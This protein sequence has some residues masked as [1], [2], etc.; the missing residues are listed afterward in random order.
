MLRARGRLTAWLAGA[1]SG[2]A[3]SLSAV[4]T[5]AASDRLAACARP[6]MSCPA[7]ARLMQ[8]REGYGRFARGGLDGTFATVTSDADSGPGSLRDIV[9]N[10][11]GPLWVMFAR[12]MTITLRTPLAVPS[13]IT[14]D[15]RDNAVTIDGNGFQLRNA[16]EHIILTHL[17][18]DGRFTSDGVAVDVF[19]GTMHVWLNNLTLSRFNDRLINVKIGATNVTISRVKFTRHN[20]VMLLNN[21]Q[22]DNL[23]RHWDRDSG[24]RVTMHRNWFVETVQ[25][26]P[27]AQ[28]GQYDIYNNLIENWSFYGMSFSLAARAEVRGNIFANTRARPCPEEG[29]FRQLEAPPSSYCSHIPRAPASTAYANGEIDRAAWEKTNGRFGYRHGW[30]AFLRVSE[31][32]YLGESRAVLADHEPDRVPVHPYCTTYRKPDEALAAAIRSEAGHRG[33]IGEPEA[34]RCPGN[35]EAAA[36]PLDIGALPWRWRAPPATNGDLQQERSVLR[37]RDL[38]PAGRASVMTQYFAAQPRARWRVA[39][40]FQVTGI[41]RAISVSVSDQRNQ[42][43]GLR[44]QCDAGGKAGASQ[45][46]GAPG[47]A[48]ATAGAASDGFSRCVIEG[49]AAAAPG[50]LIRLD[51]G[52]VEP[53]DAGAGEGTAVFRN[54]SVSRLT[55]P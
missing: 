2:L 24:S 52:L 44:G 50:N 37:L 11:A 32:L 25:R 29:P 8:A 21:I 3:L 38:A 23:F 39:F 40:D 31:N 1:L 51:L 43:A 28:F 5:A 49:F 48:T 13:F 41:G 34:A 46:T 33:R 26:H 19:D 17:D 7:V 36:A 54:I 55:A 35:V 27:R 20:K 6:D 4:I 47:T 14:I 18:I 22:D 15:G 42:G 16:A 45:P 9:T 30:K 10:A 53:R 12:D